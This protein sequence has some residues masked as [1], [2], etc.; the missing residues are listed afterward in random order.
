LY[1][2]LATMHTGLYPLPYPLRAEIMYKYNVNVT[3]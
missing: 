2:R 1:G 3:S